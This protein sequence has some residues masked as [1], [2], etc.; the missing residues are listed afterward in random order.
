MFYFVNTADSRVRSDL[1]EWSR[2]AAEL[3]NQAIEN[4][5]PLRSRIEA[6]ARM[7][8][9]IQEGALLQAEDFRGVRDSAGNLQAGAIVTDMGKYL[10]V[11]FIVTAPWN[12]KEDSPKSVRRAATML[13]AQIVRESIDLGYEG[14]IIVDAVASSADFHRRMGFIETGSSSAFAP[15]MVLT[16]EAARDFLDNLI[17]E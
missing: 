11:D 12:M 1:E 10:Y 17:G 4:D 3:V 14:R 16:P 15:E 6:N 8:S 9:L 7:I 5:L 2:V 13:M